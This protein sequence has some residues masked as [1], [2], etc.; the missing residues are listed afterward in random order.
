MCAQ[1]GCPE[2]KFKKERETEEREKWKR[3]GNAIS[4]LPFFALFNNKNTCSF[5]PFFLWLLYGFYEG[6]I[7]RKEGAENKSEQIFVLSNTGCVSA[8]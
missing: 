8:V 6:F 7:V 3:E 5:L 1:Q 4:F 2:Q